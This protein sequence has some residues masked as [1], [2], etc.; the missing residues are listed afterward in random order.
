MLGRRKNLPCT[1]SK[2]TPVLMVQNR[3]GSWRKAEAGPCSR[4]LKGVNVSQKRESPSSTFAPAHPPVG[5]SLK[6]GQIVSCLPDS[7]HGHQLESFSVTW[8]ALEENWGRDGLSS[9]STMWKIAGQPSW[10]PRQ[11]SVAYHTLGCVPFES[12]AAG[13]WVGTGTISQQQHNTT[14]VEDRRNQE[15]EEPARLT[16]WEPFLKVLWQREP[17]VKPFPGVSALERG[18]GL[19]Y[20]RGPGSI[21]TGGKYK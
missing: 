18:S 12:F 5:S 13:V 4:A 11:P 20:E 7:S 21:S 16:I 6:R 2:G 8:T 17:R 14:G 10:P 3:Q 1:L 15:R 9:C 19:S